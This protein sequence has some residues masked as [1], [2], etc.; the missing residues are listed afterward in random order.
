LIV[1][2]RSV[3]ARLEG[4]R[5]RVAR[6]GADPGALRIVAVTKGFGPDAVLAA[7][8]AG[9]SDIGE[10]YAQEMLG[11]LAA[12]PGGLRWHFLGRMQRNKLARL[13]PH[14]HLWHSLD[15]ERAAIALAARSPGAR[16]LVEVRASDEGLRGTGPQGRPGAPAGEVAGLVR[17]A[18]SAG[19]DVRG[20]MTMGPRDAPPEVVSEHFG[21]VAC[22]AHDLG[23]AELS[24]GMSG[25]FELAAAAGATI[26][27]LGQ[28]L[29][30]IRP[31]GGRVQRRD[32]E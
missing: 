12:A 21:L 26:L 32:R 7:A 19:L 20:L 29:F 31:S 9:V 23:L 2:A 22:L 13:A 30:G 15:G 4:V 14:V 25:D 24:M 18:R 17:A 5:E 3:A 27:R 11:K 28:V 16:V 1:D 6:A 8:A 10:N